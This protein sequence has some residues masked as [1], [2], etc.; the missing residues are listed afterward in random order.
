MSTQTTVGTWSYMAA[1]QNGYF[2][3]L[4]PNVNGGTAAVFRVDAFG[5]YRGRTDVVSDVGTGWT[6][7]AGLPNGEVWFFDR[8]GLHSMSAKVTSAGKLVVQKH[9]LGW[10]PFSLV[11]AV[12]LNVIVKYLPAQHVDDAG[13]AGIYTVDE[14]GGYKYTGPVPG[15]PDYLQAIVGARNGAVLLFNDNPSG[16]YNLGARVGTISEAGVFTHTQFLDGFHYF[17]MFSAK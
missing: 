3:G 2:V 14:E 17:P 15:P 1:V 11:A 5:K 8:W 16:Y 13:F 9:Q 6:H 12:N 4:D 7:L 10:W